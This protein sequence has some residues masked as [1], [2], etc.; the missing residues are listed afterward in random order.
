MKTGKKFLFFVALVFTSIQLY[1]AVQITDVKVTPISPWA[2]KIE[3]RVEGGNLWCPYLSVSNVVTHQVC[4]ASENAIEGE[5][6]LT[7]GSHSIRWN[8]MK[9]NIKWDKCNAVLAIHGYPRYCV[10]DLSAGVNAATY[11][12]TYL[13]DI[14]SGGWTE[15]Y[16]RK[17]LVLR[18]IEPGTFKMNGNDD[19]ILTKPYYIGVFEVTQAQ[20]GLVSGYYPSYYEKDNRRPVED[21]SWNQ[22]RGNSDIH[23]WPNVK[24]VADNS[25][26]GRI[27]SRTGLPVDLPTEAQWEYA[28]RAGTTSRYNNGGD[29]EG[30][31]KVLGRYSGNCKDG[32]GGYSEHTTVGSYAPNDWGLYDMHGNVWEWCLEGGHLVN[33]W[34]NIR[35]GSWNSGA[36][37][38]VSSR[39][40][41]N[42][43]DLGNSGGYSYGS[44]G[45]RLACSAEQ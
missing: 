3:Y 44:I 43:P 42:P 1:S 14:P 20:Y 26:V 30:D 40:R 39:Q 16:K 28:C 38:C 18:L 36:N 25:F 34:R 13:S 12:V 5:F 22:I 10:I 31:L 45:F 37:D 23:N 29:T 4:T 32:R 35:G 33:S 15:E 27:R 41:T 19:V 9:D 7:E 8:M 17:K 6:K 11:P 24:T 21:V 2:V